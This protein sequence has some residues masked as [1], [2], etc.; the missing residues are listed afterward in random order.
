M[1]ADALVPSAIA[2]VSKLQAAPELGNVNERRDTLFEFVQAITE[3]AR[4][5]EEKPLPKIDSTNF[6]QSVATIDGMSQGD[7]FEHLLNAAITKQLID[8]SLIHI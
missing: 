3:D 2:K 8:L 7:D 4:K 5:A 1:D 6:D